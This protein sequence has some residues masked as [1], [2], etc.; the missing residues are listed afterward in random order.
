MRGFFFSDVV[1]ERHAQAACQHFAGSGGR[2]VPLKSWE[3]RGAALGLGKRLLRTPI[4]R[5]AAPALSRLAMLPHFAQRVESA[6]K[7]G[8]SNGALDLK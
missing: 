7:R 5:A 1:G 8:A 2:V 6:E 3:A 4:A